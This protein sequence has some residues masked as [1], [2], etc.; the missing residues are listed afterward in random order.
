MPKKEVASCKHPGK[1]MPAGGPLQDI[2][3]AGQHTPAAG[4]H[5]DFE[6]SQMSIYPSTCLQDPE[7]PKVLP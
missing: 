3:Y 1:K 6:V 2:K 4:A 7:N 5:Q